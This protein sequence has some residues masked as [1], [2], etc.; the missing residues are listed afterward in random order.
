MYYTLENN[1]LKPLTGLVKVGEVQKN[2]QF[3]TSSEAAL[4]E[5]YERS[6]NKP[7]EREGYRVRSDGYELTDG[8]WATRWVYERMSVEELTQLYDAAMEEHLDAEKSARGY[9]KREPSDYANSTV[10][11]YRQDAA[12]WT[13]HRDTVMLY[14]L[15]IQ[16]KAAR[17]ETVPTLDEFKAGLPKIVW[18]I[19]DKPKNTEV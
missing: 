7:E 5:A 18:T 1:K 9:T 11:R 16:N 8:K 14:G 12:D 4:L 3:L 19:Q 10:E 2:A 13:A 6:D 15:E 17:G